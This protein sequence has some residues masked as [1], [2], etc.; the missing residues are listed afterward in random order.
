M[1]D[2]E[3][4]VINKVVVAL[5]A[6]GAPVLGAVAVWLQKVVGIH[7]DPTVA[8]T[9]VGTVVTGVVVLGLRYLHGLDVWQR[10]VRFGQEVIDAS[11]EV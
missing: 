8:A 10:L 2:V 11:K 9:Y 6:L 5:V 7:M 4:T 3:K 1:S